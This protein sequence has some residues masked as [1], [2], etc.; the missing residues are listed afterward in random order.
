LSAE[1]LDQLARIEAGAAIQSVAWGEFPTRPFRAAGE[2]SILPTLRLSNRSFAVPWP[3]FL[4]RLYAHRDS[5]VYQLLEA[6]GSDDDSSLRAL[7]DRCRALPSLVA[8]R[9]GGAVY[10]MLTTPVSDRHVAGLALWLLGGRPAQ[11]QKLNQRARLG[12]E[13]VLG[14]LLRSSEFEQ[15]YAALIADYDIP[16]EKLEGEDRQLAIEISRDCFPTQSR[17]SDVSLSDR[18]SDFLLDPATGAIAQLEPLAG[19]G[20]FPD[21]DT[22]RAVRADASK[23]VRIRG[24]S[25]GIVTVVCAL[26]GADQAEAVLTSGDTEIMRVKLTEARSG[27]WRADLEIPKERFG[28]APFVGTLSLTGPL[29]NTDGCTADVRIEPDEQLLS[30]AKAA[31]ARILAKAREAANSGYL[32]EGLA[33][34]RRLVG[35]EYDDDA[36]ASILELTLRAL[37]GEDNADI[38]A[39]LNSHSGQSSAISEMR[40][41]IALGQEDL[42]E[43]AAVF[44]ACSKLELSSEA[45]LAGSIA[46]RRHRE[47]ASGETGAEL[48]VPPALVDIVSQII[49]QPRSRINAFTRAL[50]QH[51]DR[52]QALK[53]ANLVLSTLGLSLAPPRRLA[54]LIEAY[55]DAGLLSAQDLATEKA[56]SS[57]LY[58]YLSALVQLPPERFSKPWLLM[59]LARHA[60]RAS[61]P[62]AAAALADRVQRLDPN[63]LEALTTSGDA[64][65]VLGDTETALDRF[66]GLIR[67]RPNDNR[68][69][70]KVLAAELTLARRDPL[71]PRQRLNELLQREADQ[72]RRAVF[73]NPQ[74]RQARMALARSQVRSGE[75]ESAWEI[76]RSVVASDATIQFDSHYELLKQSFALGRWDDVLEVG[77]HILELREFHVDTVLTMVKALRAKGEFAAATEMLQVWL[78]QGDSAI[79]QE[80]VRDHFYRAEFAEAV[81]LADKYL[82]SAEHDGLEFHLLAC[83]AHLELGLYKA[84]AFHLFRAQRLGAPEKYPLEYPLF[85]SATAAKEGKVRSSL[86]FLDSMFALSG[87]QSVRFDPELGREYFDRLVGTGRTA[88]TEDRVSPRHDGPL[89]SV[90]MTSYNSAAYI[91]TAVRSILQQ[92][93]ENLELIIVDDA[94]TDGTPGLLRDLESVD[95]RVVC[96]F[97]QTNDGTYVSKNIGLLRARGAYVALQDSDDWSHPDRIRRSIEILEARPELM[98]LTTDWIRMTSGGEVVIKAG[99]QIAHLCCISLVFRRGPVVDAIGFFDSVRIAADLE[100]IERIGLRFGSDAVPRIKTPLLFGRTRSDSLTASEEYGILRTGFTPTRQEYHRAAGEFH[101][102]I[103]KGESSFIPFPLV[104]RRFPAPAIILPSKGQH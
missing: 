85:L 76:L 77:N 43:A 1:F 41:L 74:D 21:L 19:Q 39:A 42:A 38:V 101:D 68:V 94:S 93:Y 37:M 28:P 44:R 35:I 64:Y 54:E 3:T 45:H 104:E 50:A 63:N 72:A 75:I 2:T 17:E 79:Q 25:S 34:L 84:A 91:G 47:P 22:L 80:Y 98:A 61:L 27:G 7:L 78:S 24:H 71:R 31:R 69:L 99:G 49:T 95:P 83:A 23:P 32:R 13:H 92:S 96:I 97:K 103:R 81:D 55:E 58:L 89:V 56:A 60:T 5:A 10:P 36:A 9:T 66:E 67:A 51:N 29:E 86:E 6:T 12:Y 46:A 33:H 73:V 100:F 102:R 11:P 30:S 88:E 18:L 59:R 62:F 53:I 70:Q 4:A 40:I 48:D 15:T 16:A 8:Q 82:Q 52:D 14:D 90:I 65:R 57:Q 26:P 87:S 20:P